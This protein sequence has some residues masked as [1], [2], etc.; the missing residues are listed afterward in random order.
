ML[1][2][3]TPNMLR[4]VELGGIISYMVLHNLNR[5]PSQLKSEFDFEGRI[6]TLITLAILKATLDLYIVS[7]GETIFIHMHRVTKQI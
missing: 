2:F 7:M 4:R 6:S 3:K 1:Q 5:R